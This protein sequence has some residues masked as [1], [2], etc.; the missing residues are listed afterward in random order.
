MYLTLLTRVERPR[1]P[2][3]RETQFFHRHGLWV[4]V[5]HLSPKNPKAS[6]PALPRRG[7]SRHIWIGVGRRDKSRLAL[8][9]VKA[10]SSYQHGGSNSNPTRCSERTSRAVD[11]KR[12][13]PSKRLCNSSGRRP[14]SCSSLHLTNAN[15]VAR[16]KR[17]SNRSRVTRTRNRRNH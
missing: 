13:V 17:S 16:R 9:G 14:K 4:C 3:P 11:R 8:P 1:D 5:A 12:P 10:S 7:Q 6:G 15:V 2:R